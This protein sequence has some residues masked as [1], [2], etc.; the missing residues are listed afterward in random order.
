MNRE[1][2]FR[3]IAFMYIFISISPILR[4]MPQAL[5]KEAGR[6]GYLSPLISI[7]AILPITGI[8]IALLKLFPGLNF[9][10][11]M[12][13]LL[14]KVLSKV[15]LLGYILWIFVSIASKVNAYA[16]TLQFTLMPNTQTDFL[17]IALIFLVYYALSRGM[18]TVFR[19]SEFTL[20]SIILLF[21]VLFICALP[22]LRM[23]YLLPVSTENLP[24]TISASKQVISIGGNIIMIL[25]FAD[26]FDLLVSKLQFRKLWGSVMVLI[27]LAF[28]LTVFTFGITGAPLTAKLPFPFYIT[29]KSISFFNAFERFEV[30]V[31]LI[32][33][34]SDFIAI[35]IYSIVL[36]RSVEW[37]FNL[38][39]ENYL[40]VPITMI[41]YYATFYIST[42]VFEFAFLYQMIIVNANIIF[43]YIIPLFLGL[44]CLLK[45]KMIRKQY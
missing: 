13:Q 26:K 20:G 34:I 43:Q 7:I 29:V 30:L 27:L 10:E 35:C 41:L 2:S 21:I 38:R 12:V 17:I 45:R 5:A 18:K 22:K 1:V 31:T 3:Q 40:Y 32:C 19:F 6:S 44:V 14:G 15:L 24:S 42:T 4:Q 25:F 16:S 9:Y 11:I 37:L 36:I 28:G 39:K 33:M 8:I 23:D